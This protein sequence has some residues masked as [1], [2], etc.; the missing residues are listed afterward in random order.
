[1]LAQRLLS[2]WL[3]SGY[4]ITD[5]YQTAGAL[6]QN[7]RILL[8]NNSIKL[9]FTSGIFIGLFATCFIFEKLKKFKKILENTKHARM[10]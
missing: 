4:L 1:M 3:F 9:V 6:P 7:Y 5:I 2:C 8:V 10:R